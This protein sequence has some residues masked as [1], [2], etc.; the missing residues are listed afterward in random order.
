M[1]G[2]AVHAWSVLVVA[3]VLIWLVNGRHGFGTQVADYPFNYHPLFMVLAFL[4]LE[5]QGAQRSLYVARPITQTCW[6]CRCEI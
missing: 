6:L 1:L 2:F 5:T 3:L 4:G